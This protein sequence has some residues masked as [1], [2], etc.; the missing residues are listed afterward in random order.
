MYYHNKTFYPATQ[1]FY[2]DTTGNVRF[3]EPN[4][5]KTEDIVLTR[6]H[7]ELGSQ[8]FKTLMIGGEFQAAN[9]PDFSDAVL[10]HRITV[11]PEAAYNFVDVEISGRYQ[12]FRYVSP[13]KGS[14]TNVA[15]IEFYDDSG[16]QLRGTVIGTEGSYENL[17]NDKYKAFDG[18]TLTFSTLPNL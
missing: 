14:Y 16:Q 4:P 17:G 10:L 6:K 2:M 18:N 8:L 15:E 5:E 9:R 13:D 11:M 1:S 7:P 3:F 12:Y